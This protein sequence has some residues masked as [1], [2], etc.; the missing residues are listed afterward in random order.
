MNP[1]ETSIRQ[2]TEGCYRLE[3]KS[4]TIGKGSCYFEP[5]WD[6]QFEGITMVFSLSRT[7]YRRLMSQMRGGIP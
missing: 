6:G 4:Q 2:T 3:G 5:Y 1:L 7:P